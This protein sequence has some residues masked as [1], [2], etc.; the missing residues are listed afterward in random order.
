MVRYLAPLLGCLIVTATVAE[1]VAQPRPVVEI[2]PRADSAGDDDEGICFLSAR[3]RNTGSSNLLLLNGEATAHHAT[4]GQA[5]RVPMST[6]GFSGVGPGETREWGPVGILDVRCRDVR[7]T[8]R[9]VVCASG[10][11]EPVWRH[12]GIA[13][14]EVVP[15]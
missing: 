13:G 4:T 7:L 11:A 12:R 9:N 14:L 15:R 6:M 3:V 8:L 10:C 2:G 1:A 5:L